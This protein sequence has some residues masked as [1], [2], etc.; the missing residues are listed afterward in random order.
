MEEQTAI[1]TVEELVELLDLTKLHTYELIAT[2]RDEHEEIPSDAEPVEPGDERI[3]VRTGIRSREAGLDYRVEVSV[4]HARGQILA[5]MGAFYESSSP[6]ELTGDSEEAVTEFGDRV[7]MMVLFPYLRQAISD[8]GHRVSVE[9]TLPMLR[10]GQL[11]F[12]PNEGE[13][14]GDQ[15]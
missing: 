14:D 13:D 8:L 10:P 9:I 5:D 15:A 12:A 4:E 7:A 1:T 6:M 2:A 11:T 3:R